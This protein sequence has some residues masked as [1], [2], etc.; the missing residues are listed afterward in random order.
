M[1]C[2][3]CG[4]SENLKE[5]GNCHNVYYCSRDC[6]FEDWL[7]HKKICLKKILY[8]GMADD[9]WTVLQ[10]EEDFDT[11]YVIDKF[12]EAYGGTVEN[13]RELI[14]RVITDGNNSAYDD[15]YYFEFHKLRHKGIIQSESLID[16]VWRLNFK[17]G[18]RNLKLII[19][20]K[21][22]RSKE[23]P[24]EINHL[25]HVLMIGSG[26]WEDFENPLFL[27]MMT[28]RTEDTFLLTALDF[29]NEHFPI[30]TN[31]TNRYYDEDSE[32]TEAAS[33]LIKKQPDGSIN[34]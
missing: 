20:Y 3:T 10:L 15:G 9:I 26:T 16:N 31:F 2:N 4:K 7:N 30:K 28:E 21:N 13:Q 24:K 32:F 14:K 19:Y 1:N 17:Y 34:L 12:D 23:W 25:S 11:I 8:L 27:K 33:I 5:C 29:L 6:Q 22:F 18:S